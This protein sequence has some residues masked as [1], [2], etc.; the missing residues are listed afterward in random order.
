MFFYTCK[1]AP[2]T[3][4]EMVRAR[5]MMHNNRIF[6]SLGIGAL[7]SMIRNANDGPAV[8]G[9][10][11]E[12]SHGESSDYN[13][14]DDEVI[15]EEEVN[16]NVVD[17]NVKVQ[18]FNLFGGV[19]LLVCFVLHYLLYI[20]CSHNILTCDL[21]LLSLLFSVRSQRFLGRRR[22]PLRSRRQHR[23]GRDQKHLH[24]WLREG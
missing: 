23:G 14:R 3:E 6:Q 18:T 19:G 21:M 2:L 5:N 20:T 1:E 11:N 17:K 16:D 15:E 22:A 4:Y 9:I 10:T 12:E 13:P 24:Q 8:S 7:G